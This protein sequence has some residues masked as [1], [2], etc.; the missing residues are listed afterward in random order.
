MIQIE[1]ADPLSADSQALIEKLSAVLA[2]ITG[3]S[4]KRSFN[5]AD[6]QSARA[7]WALARNAQGTAI[8]CGAIRPLTQ[9]TAELKR[10]FSTGSEAGAAVRFC[11][12]WKRPHARLAIV[13]SP[14]KRGASTTMP[15]R[16]IKSMATPL[17]TIM[18][19]ISAGMTQCVLSRPCK[20]P[21]GATRWP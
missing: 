6:L 5:I 9:E 21:P 14:S 17:P 10:M 15:W 4:G 13:K 8:G 1:K 3:S 12:F 19:P 7:V 20:L 16:F 2:Q 11:T 18:A